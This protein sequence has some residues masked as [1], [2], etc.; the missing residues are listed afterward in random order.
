VVN[1]VPL[2][3]WPVFAK[4][5]MNALMLIQDNKVALKPS[6]DQESGLAGRDEVA[7]VV[8]GLME[9]EEGRRIWNQMNDLED[10]WLKCSARTGPPLGH[11][12][13][14]LSN[15]RPYL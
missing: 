14:W 6:A 2:I 12:L 3:V 7:R 1:G 4:Q 9:G 13:S 11:F 15:R 8:K 5:R 10:A